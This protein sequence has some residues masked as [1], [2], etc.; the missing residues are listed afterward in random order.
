MF[1]YALTWVWKENIFVDPKI[2]YHFA[3]FQLE[4]WYIVSSID[5]KFHTTQQ[6]ILNHDYY[7]PLS[8][9]T[10]FNQN[11]GNMICFMEFV[12]AIDFYPISDL[13]LPGIRSIWSFLW[14][15]SSSFTLAMHSITFHTWES[16]LAWSNNF[17]NGSFVMASTRWL[18]LRRNV[19]QSLLCE[20]ERCDFGI[21]NYTC[22][23]EISA[24]FWQQVNLR[25]SH[26]LFKISDRIRCFVFFF[27]IENNKIYITG[28][29]DN[30]TWTCMIGIQKF[31]R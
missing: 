15:C 21:P 4:V 23:N 24:I 1:S 10:Q 16:V 29:L 2:Q 18:K 9:S 17:S 31:D 26:N 13:I 30:P 20:F 22:N 19:S 14:K 3:G 12:I 7:E 28:V 8:R 11:F 6:I 5:V 25:Q 27:Q